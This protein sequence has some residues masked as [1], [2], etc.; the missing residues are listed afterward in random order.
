MRFDI[1]GYQLPNDTSGMLADFFL[2]KRDAENRGFRLHHADGVYWLSRPLSAARVFETRELDHCQQYIRARSGSN[3]LE[4]SG[5]K[6]AYPR[7]ARA[8]G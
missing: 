6:V 8:G 2:V 1:R 7:E 5:P 3:G 4:D